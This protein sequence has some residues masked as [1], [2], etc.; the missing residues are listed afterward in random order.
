MMVGF[1]K[2]DASQAISVRSARMFMSPL[3]D[4]TASLTDI[5]NFEFEALLIR[6]AL[7]PFTR[8]EGKL[9]AIRRDHTPR[10]ETLPYVCE[11]SVLPEIQ[12]SILSART[13]GRER[14]KHWPLLRQHQ[15]GPRFLGPRLAVWI[16]D[17]FHCA[18]RM[19]KP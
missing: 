11:D 19:Q 13:W 6:D 1:V 4:M 12:T 5:Y 14:C 17:L 9:A 2:Y 10:K 8:E 15:P 7:F 3:I 18:G 16:E